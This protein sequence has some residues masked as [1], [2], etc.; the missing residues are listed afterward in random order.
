M[1]DVNEAPVEQSPINAPTELEKLDARIAALE[2]KV[3]SFSS[4]VEKALAKLFHPSQW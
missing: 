3:D 1:S 2:E 4:R